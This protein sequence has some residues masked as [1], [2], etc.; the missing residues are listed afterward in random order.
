[1]KD[2]NKDINK[3]EGKIFRLHKSA[4][5]SLRDWSQSNVIGQKERDEILDPT[6]ADAKNEITS[7]PSPFARIDLIKTAFNE[8]NQIQ[9]NSKDKKCHLDGNTIFHKMVSETLDVAEIFFNFPNFEDKFE[10]INWDKSQIKM[11]GDVS[12][13]LRDSLK[14]FFK[15]DESTYN[16]DKVDSMYLLNYKGEGTPNPDLNIIGATSPST[17]FFSSNNDL[18]YIGRYIQ[19]EKFKPF[20]KDN[21]TP[22]YKRDFEFIKYLFSFR[23]SNTNFNNLFP[24]FDSYLELTFKYLEEEKKAIIRNLED[25]YYNNNYDPFVNKIEILGNDIYCRKQNPALIKD[26]SQFVIRPDLELNVQNLPLIIPNE[27]NSANYTDLIY[28]NDKWSSTYQININDISKD[29][30]NRTLPNSGEKYPYH[31]LED[32]FEDKLIGMIHPIN[33]DS[34]FSG[35]DNSDI[36][37][38]EEYGFLIPL[39]KAYFDYFTPNSLYGRIGGKN[40]FEF[41]RINNY[42]I[43]AILRIPIKGKGKNEYIEYYKIYSEFSDKETVDPQI[44]IKRFGLSVFPLIKFNEGEMPFYNVA[45]IDTNYENSSKIEIELYKSNSKIDFN[46]FERLNSS[47]NTLGLN[48]YSIQDN[49]DFMQLKFDSEYSCVIIPKF[50]NHQGNNI[51]KFAVDFGT[52]NTH[53]EY[54]ENESGP[55]PF[56]IEDDK[57]IH[58]LNTN[59]DKEDE[60]KTAFNQYIIPE[61]INKDSNYN[62]PIRTVILESNKIKKG[63]NLFVLNEVNIPFVYEKSNIDVK[64]NNITSNIKWN[65]KEKEKTEKFLEYLIIAMRNKVL[66]NNGKLNETKIIWSYPTSLSTFGKSLLESYWNELCK[67]Y[68]NIKKERIF[69]ISE[70]IAPYYYF[71]KKKG[72]IADVLSIDIGGGTTDIVFVENKTP[73]LL[74]SFRFAANN[75]FGDGI[76]NSLENNSFIQF[77]EEKLKECEIEIPKGIN[78]DSSIDLTTFYFSIAKNKDFKDK[79][80]KYEEELIKDSQLKYIFLIFYTSIIFH[81]AKLL[82]AND[83]KSPNHITFTGNGSRIL[84]IIGDD[85]QIELL[86]S[87]IFKGVFDN[88]NKIKIIR[89]KENPKEATAKGSLLQIDRTTDE[90]DLN[91]IKKIYNPFDENELDSIDGNCKSKLIDEVKE[92]YKIFTAINKEIDYKDK[93]NTDFSM[94]IKIDEIFRSDDL[95]KYINYKINERVEENKSLGEGNEIDETM[96]FYAIEG[97]MKEINTMILKYNQ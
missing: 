4:N 95:T 38:N 29:I 88:D 37:Y 28:I 27:K 78:K 73:K 86:T 13:I 40:R 2:K 10:I 1:M 46:K 55:K 94:L 74:S 69:K 7:I 36:E 56:E 76:A 24:E 50:Q 45:L 15:Q 79:N 82:K 70:S 30:N 51:F 33:N 6:G 67:K 87:K 68:F 71:S 23:K 58:K 48:L 8:I 32:F 53:I 84:N 9:Q 12:P 66:I 90:V 72:A 54:Y 43:K 77:Y 26:K 25:N 22:L 81:T 92:F 60:I 5:N 44:I 21:F 97:I 31:V 96:F 62:F 49:F 42:S 83:C 93:F 65:H 16:F 20:D 39:K 41:E 18:S 75:V 11:I 19:F 63:N 57:Q 17:L 85:K 47:T 91:V 35:E 89:N 3:V 59:Y 80:F 61:I 34:F 64:N 14:I 52:T